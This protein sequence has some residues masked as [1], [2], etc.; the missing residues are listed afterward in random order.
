MFCDLHVDGF[1][2]LGA[3]FDIL[4]PLH[5]VNSWVPQKLRFFSFYNENSTKF[6]GQTKLG[7]SWGDFQVIKNELYGDKF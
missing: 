7:I 5:Q 3:G 6:K 4:F 2:Q 1:F